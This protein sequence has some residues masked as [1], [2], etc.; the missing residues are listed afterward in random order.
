MNQPTH[1][2]GFTITYDPP[3]IPI[4]S[5]DYQFC[6]DDYNGP[7]DGRCGSAVSEKAAM[8]EID[9]ML[10]D[11][12]PKDTLM[13]T[14]ISNSFTEAFLYYQTNCAEKP[15]MC[16][17]NTESPKTFI[18]ASSRT[19]AAKAYFNHITKHVTQVDR[20]GMAELVAIEFSKLSSTK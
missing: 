16:V 3:P 15:V 10:N 19:V 9:E 2:R 1:Y 13:Q 6:H 11:L 7:E 5:H 18:V 17:D 8:I 12:Q 4:R 20:D 14:M